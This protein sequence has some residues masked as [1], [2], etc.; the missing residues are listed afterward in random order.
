MKKILVFSWFYPPV[1]SS[2]AV[3]TFKLLN[4]SKYCY[5]V[6]SQNGNDSWSYGKDELL[7]NNKNVNTI[8]S[9]ST[10]LKGWVD[11][12]VNYYVENRDKYDLVMT[13]S[14]PPES[15]AVGLKIKKINPYVKWIASFGDPISNNPYEDIRLLNYKKSKL[16]RLL[17]K[18]RIKCLKLKN[19]NLEKKIFKG[20]DLLIFNSEY[21]KNFMLKDDCNYLILPHSYD[22]KLFKS[23]NNKVINKKINIS[24]FG[25]LDNTRNIHLLLEVLKD[26]KKELSNLEDK[27]EIKL[28]GS[29]GS[30][31]K[32]YILENKLD[33]IVKIESAVGYLVS[34]RKMQEADYLL[35]VDA[36]LSPIVNSNIFFA[37]KLADYLGSGKPIIGITMLDGISADILRTTGNLVL[38]Y[39][40]SDIRNYLLKIINC[41]YKMST[42]LEEMK[43]Y[44]SKCVSATFDKKLGEVIKGEFGK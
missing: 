26:I 30:N 15:H 2:E 37:A 22:E 10:D 24:Y 9:S 17:L 34:L 12:A 13:R 43:K 33:D 23:I 3:V 36:N 19:S 25:G 8:Y 41:E 11:E 28:Y 31:D 27:I 14:M 18:C 4:N 35:F 44:N 39:S 16:K 21:Q 42:N 6:F 7:K 5:D 1:N 40:K 38:T 32:E 20:S 29:I